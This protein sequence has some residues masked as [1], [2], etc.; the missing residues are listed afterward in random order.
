MTIKVGAAAVASV[1]LIAIWSSGAALAQKRGGILTMYIW[2]NPPSMSMLDGLNPLAA[3]AT[4]SVFN[5]LV[6]FDQHVKQSSL[7]SIVPDLATSWSWSEEGTELTFP[8]RQG[9][10][11]HDGKPFSAKDVKCTWDLLLDKSSDKLR[12][13][14]RKSWYRNL[15]EVTTNGDYEVTFH[16]KRPQPALLT[17]LASG[18]SP[19]Y[20]CHVPAAQM[21]QH[22]IGTGPFKFAEFKPNEYIKVTRNPDYWKKDRP[23]L[24][25]IEYTIIKNM[26]TATLAFIAG[27]FDM[28][29]PNTLTVPL[30]KDVQKQMPQAICELTPDGGI[31]RHL[32]VNPDKP[33]FDNPGL[34][35]AMALSLDRKAFIDTISQGQ[36]EIGGVLQPLPEGLWGMPPQMLATLPG[37][38][39]D[40]A[41]NRAEAR[42]VMQRLGYGPDNRLKIKVSTRDLPAYRDPAVILIDQLKEVYIDGELEII[43]TSLYFP[44]I[45]RKDYTVALNNAA[46]GPDPDP[47]LD[48]QY[49]CGSSLNLNDYCNPEMDE[50]IE[51]QS[52]EGDPERRKPLLWAIERKL[53]EDG[54]RP[55]IFYSRAGTCWQPWVKG[56]T[57][58]VDSLFNANRMEDVWLDK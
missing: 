23:Y 16:L 29:F 1:L 7:S 40:I 55:I 12:I 39:P 3:R 37:Y 54:A 47:I 14:T 48:A 31:N 11:W 58:M 10:K 44:K 26:S 42:K 50:L 5:N 43:D 22:P 52:R 25:G 13:N 51:Q 33:P 38:D 28:T 2:D 53:A 20:P 21:R 57:I 32:L 27:K 19:V 15:D 46:S 24:D 34:R 8:L 41:K 30:W 18:W 9:V 6:M 17:L 35:H 36:G 49:G 4:M 56:L 45:L